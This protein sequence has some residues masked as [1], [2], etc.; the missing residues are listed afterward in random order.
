VDISCEFA[1]GEAESIRQRTGVPESVS[2]EKIAKTKI[3][4][5]YQNYV[6]GIIV[7]DDGKRKL[8]VM[9]GDH[10]VFL[11]FLTGD[12]DVIV[13]MNGEYSWATRVILNGSKRGDFDEIRIE[14][15]S[16]ETLS[17][18]IN[19]FALK[20]GTSRSMSLF[21]LPPIIQEL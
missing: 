16:F 1:P 7:P 18:S 20:T 5:G 21:P 14:K 19:R 12:R 17:D 13:G 9:F 11:T 15:E 6:S 2:I 8:V 10:S 4:K 3:L